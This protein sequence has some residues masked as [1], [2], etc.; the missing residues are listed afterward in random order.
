MVLGIG[1]TPPSLLEKNIKS[2]FFWTA[3]L[4]FN[5]MFYWEAFG[6]SIFLYM[7]QQLID[8]IAENASKLSSTTHLYKK[9]EGLKWADEVPDGIKTYHPTCARFFSFSQIFVIF[10]IAHWSSE[11]WSQCDRLTLVNIER[12]SSWR[13]DNVCFWSQS[14]SQAAQ[15]A[16]GLMND[17]FIRE[18]ERE[19]W[20]ETTWKWREVFLT[21]RVV[22]EMK[23]LWNQLANCKF[24][25]RVKN[26]LPGIYYFARDH[27]H[28]IARSS[29]RAAIRGM[30]EH[31]CWSLGIISPIFDNWIF[32]HLIWYLI[33]HTC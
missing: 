5:G 13:K 20:L 32:D 4:K 2:R 14:V 28:C 3:S 15:P 18:R 16:K 7:F 24:A 22:A 26:I 9:K 11:L 31:T 19:R 12:R 17:Q 29:R 23:D 21:T 33:W 8:W 30:M 27:F 10:V 6:W 25:K 1:K